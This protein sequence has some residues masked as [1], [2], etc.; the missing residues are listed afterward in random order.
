MPFVYRSIKKAKWDKRKLD[1]LS[2]NESQADILQ[3][4]KSTDNKLSVWWLEELEANLERFLAAFAAKRDLIGVVDFVLFDPRYLDNLD[5]VVKK[6][7]GDTLDREVNEKLHRDLI[8]LTLFKVANLARNLNDDAVFLDD[9]TRKISSNGRS[10]FVIRFRVLEVARLITIGINSGAIDRVTLTN[11]KNSKIV[12]KLISL[13]HL[14]PDPPLPTNKFI[15]K[16]FT[17][18]L[19]FLKKCFQDYISRNRN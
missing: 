17:S 5:I 4:F 12:D 16:L 15:P 13:G 19:S 14:E 10:V 3:D 1:W 7:N 8:E 6:T 18:A 2:P 11:N 9:N